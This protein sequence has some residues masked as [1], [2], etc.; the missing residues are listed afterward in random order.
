MMQ[1]SPYRITAKRLVY[2][3]DGKL[4]AGELNTFKRM[5]ITCEDAFQYASDEGVLDPEDVQG[6]MLTPEGFE[7][8]KD[9]IT[10]YLEHARN[11]IAGGDETKYT[12]NMKWLAHLLQKPGEKPE[13]S[14]RFWF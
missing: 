13:L 14:A 7:K 4:K 11:I 12:Y 3:P 10:P 6:D 2:A 8:I 9:A 1:A 5:A